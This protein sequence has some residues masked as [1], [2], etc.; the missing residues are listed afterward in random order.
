MKNYK[1][2]PIIFFLLYLTGCNISENGADAWGN[3]EA[4]ETIIS[5]QAQGKLLHLNTPRGTMLDKEMHVGLIDTTQYALN[6]KALLAKKESVQTRL[7]E[8]DANIAV[9]Q[10]QLTNLEREYNRARNLLKD[11]AATPQ[12]VEELEG[13]IQVADR[14]IQAARISKTSVNAE[15]QAMDAQIALAREQLENCVIVNP[16]NGTVLEKYTEP[17]EL[18]MPGKALYKIGDLSEMELKVFISG[19]QLPHVALGQKVK[20]FI[21]EDDTSNRMMEGTVSWISSRAEFTPKTIQTKE[22][23]VHQVY[24]VKISVPNDGSI[25]IG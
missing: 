18:V 15:L 2:A 17:H 14:Q 4:R 3:F 23:R 24:A 10:S 8:I 22:E 19:S 25:K 21:D 7:K 13:K 1:T 16:L 12:Q 20:I 6:H 9:L 5:A 11:K